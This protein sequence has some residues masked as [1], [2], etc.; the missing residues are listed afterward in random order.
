MNYLNLALF[1]FGL[2]RLTDESFLTYLDNL[3]RSVLIEEY[4]I[5]NV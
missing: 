1:A 2:L 4:H 3:V 5:V